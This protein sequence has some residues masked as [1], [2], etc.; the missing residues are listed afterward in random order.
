MPGFLPLPLASGDPLLT[1]FDTLQEVS[2]E[3]TFVYLLYLTGQWLI[4]LTISLD[5]LV[6]LATVMVHRYLQRHVLIRE[7]GER[8]DLSPPFSD[9]QQE[10]IWAVYQKGVRA[11]REAVASVGDPPDS[12]ERAD[13]AIAR[14]PPSRPGALRRRTD[15]SHR[16]PPPDADDATPRLAP[17]YTR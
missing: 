9:P 10:R 11:E 1:F 14:T 16:N 2:T 12:R 5:L 4:G 15:G 3:F 8:L 17:I 6:L 7:M 13:D